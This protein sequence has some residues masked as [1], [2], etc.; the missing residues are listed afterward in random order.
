ML[1][2]L[3]RVVGSISSREVYQG[4]RVQ[5]GPSP[6][7]TLGSLSLCLAGTMTKFRTGRLN[8][9]RLSWANYW[10][11]KNLLGH[12]D[13]NQSILILPSIFSARK[14]LLYSML[15]TDTIASSCHIFAIHY[16]L[17]SRSFNSYLNTISN[18]MPISKKKME[19]QWGHVTCLTSRN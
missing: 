13:M 7:W 6:E 12:F 15:F 1:R 5:C 4:D 2:G 14:K 8:P 3:L 16:W 17:G 10:V 18:I 19:V 11:M 9:G